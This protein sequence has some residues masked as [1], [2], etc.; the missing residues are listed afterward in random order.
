M[1]KYTI[2]D[3]KVLASV[4]SSYLCIDISDWLDIV[5]S[6]IES[7]KA[8]HFRDMIK[9]TIY[10]MIGPYSFAF[11]KVACEQH[12]ISRLIFKTPLNQM[13]LCI[14]SE[15]GWERVISQW[16]LSIER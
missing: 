3:L 7:N 5:K 2:K 13:P 15:K 8:M 1:I 10:E 16:R 14:S 9:A 12:G 6:S 11:N 4:L